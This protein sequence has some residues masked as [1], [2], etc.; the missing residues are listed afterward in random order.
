MEHV[1]A[2]LDNNFGG[3]SIDSH[4][5]NANK[6]LYFIENLGGGQI[7]FR[8]INLGHPYKFHNIYISG[9]RVFQCIL[10]IFIGRS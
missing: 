3:S 2:P 1:G 9:I 5:S 8:P 7:L 4:D 6:K 10:Y